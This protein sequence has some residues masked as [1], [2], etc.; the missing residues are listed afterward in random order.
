MTGLFAPN[1]LAFKTMENLIG[2][3][4]FSLALVYLGFKTR[5]NHS[6]HK[7]RTKVLIENLIEVTKQVS[8]I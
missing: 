4:V 2:E 8:V 1:F 5:K 6:K 3:I 7:Q